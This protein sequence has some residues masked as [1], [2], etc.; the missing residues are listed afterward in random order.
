MDL[1]AHARHGGE[2]L[3][4]PGEHA[5][6]TDA[7][8]RLRTE[9]ADPGHIRDVVEGC[10]ERRRHDRKRELHQRFHDRTLR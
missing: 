4:E 6:D 5:A 9:H 3:R 2:A 7:G 8:D 10:D 1:T